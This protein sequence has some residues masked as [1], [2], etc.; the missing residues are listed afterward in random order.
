MRT[1]SLSISQRAGEESDFRCSASKWSSTRPVRLLHANL[2]RDMNIAKDLIGLPTAAVADVL[3]I[4]GL[5]HRALSSALRPLGASGR[6]CA[7]AFCVRG[8]T[9]MG[10]EPKDAKAVRHAMFHRALEGKVLVMSTG[11][12]A[13]SAVFGENVALAVR[14]RGCCGVMVDGGVRDSESL[15]TM[16]IPVFARFSTPVSNAG[17]WRYVA[18]EEPVLMP[19]QTSANVLVYPGDVLLG[20]R[21]GVMV[22][23]SQYAADVAA[24]ARRLI[25]VEEMQRPRLVRGDDPKEVY[26]SG[27]RYG[28]IRQYAAAAD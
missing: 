13:E 25:A 23:P 14:A 8:E 19:G 7:P 12:Y 2:E 16:D 4:G 22:I 26:A 20:D 21:D 11:G 28:H 24:D 27:D 17:R 1:H 6:L 10:P 5:Q 15:A 18:L 3:R 9:A